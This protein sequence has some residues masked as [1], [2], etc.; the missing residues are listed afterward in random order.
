MIKKAQYICIHKK[1]VYLCT[2][3]Q[4]MMTLS[5]YEWPIR[6]SVRTSGFHPGKRGSTPLWAT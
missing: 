1:K 2:R 4:E 5:F 6:L 3:N